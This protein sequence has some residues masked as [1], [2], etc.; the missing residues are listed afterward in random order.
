[1]NSAAN[2]TVDKNKIRRAIESGLPLMLTT[3]T[4]PHEM[5]MYMNAV[6]AAF[7]EEIGKPQLKEYMTYCLSELVGN[8]K[9]AN[10]KRIYFKEKSLDVHNRR[11]YMEGMKT[12]K[13]DTLDN[14]HHYLEEQ[15][16]AGLYIRLI[17]QKRNDKVRIEVRN[18]SALSYFEYVRIHD[19]MSRAQQYKSIDQAL[20]QLLDDSEGAGLG[21]VIMILMLKKLGFSEESYQVKS[22]CGETISRLVLPINTEQRES[23]SLIS[24]EFVNLIEDLPQFPENIAEINRLLDNP[25]SKMSDI[26][27]KIS[28]DVSMTAD[29]LRLVNSASFSRSVRCRS[30]GDAVKFVGIR[31]VKNMLYSIGSIKNLSKDGEKETERKKELWT[32]AYK[33]AFYA[34]NIAR[35][36]ISD[37]RECVEDSYV[38]ALLHDMG[39]IIFETAHPDLIE[40]LKTILAHKGISADLFEK[41]IAGVDHAEIGAMIAEK[42]NFPEQIIGVIRYHHEPGE[43][44]ED[45]RNL[46]SVVYIA[47]MIIHYQNE[48]IDFEDIDFDVLSRLK[49]TDKDNFTKLSDAI[50]EAFDKNSK[51]S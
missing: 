41:L 46:C 42:W 38:C 12:F 49:L 3:Y 15:E 6:L 32:H 35:N 29:L 37:D 30:I 44:P 13:Q 47:D 8:A 5:E 2:Y 25:N 34:Y 48:E 1:M 39:K 9:K 17:L 23:I 28:N 51:M 33:A 24:S 7:L 22:E 10:T 45:I 18:N 20:K 16:K 14:I 31:G 21:L 4:L 36:I 40:K 11:D 19:K 50:K 26:A 27:E 43:A